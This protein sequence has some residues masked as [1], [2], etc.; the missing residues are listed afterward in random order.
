[1]GS[2]VCKK[3]FKQENLLVGSGCRR[4]C[5]SIDLAGRL[6]ACAEFVILG[7]DLMFVN[8]SYREIKYSFD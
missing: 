8:Q 5:L 6:N 1:M 7:A 3:L 2:D 4:L